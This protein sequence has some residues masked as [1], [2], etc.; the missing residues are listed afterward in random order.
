MK[1]VGVTKCPS[2]VAH[3][4]MA[5]EMLQETGEEM[6]HE[7]RIETQGSVGTE[8]E[9]T[10][11][12]IEA[13]DYVVIAADIAIDGMERFNGKKV[14]E[15]PIQPVLQDCEAV[16]N[17]LPENA[18]LQGGE[19]GAESTS[20]SG[21]A[22]PMKALMDGASHMI[23]FVVTG[24][25][26]M[27]LATA[28]GGVD[29]S[30]NVATDNAFWYTTYQVGSLAFSL[31]YPILA[32]YIANAIAGR[33][34][35]APAMISAYVA[36]TP[37]VLGTESSMGFL[38][39]VLSGFLA[40]YLVKWMN[41]WNVGKY[42]KPL[43]PIFIIPLVGTALISALYICV[44]GYPISWIMDW[45]SWALETLAGN[46]ATSWALSI[47][48]GIMISSDMGGPINKVAF[49]TGTASI[50]TGA[51]DVM[52]LVAVAIPIPALVC[53]LATLL[54]P[55][56]YT[57]EEK[58]SGISALVMGFTGLTEGA[59]P[60]A[61]S[62]PLHVIPSCMVGTCAGTIVAGWMG[63]ECSIPW[64]GPIVALLGATNNILGY[65]V[66]CI[67]GMVV[68]GIMLAAWK[69]HSDSKKA[70]EAETAEA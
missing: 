31:M 17:G 20:S 36:V 37:E 45:L 67:I 32:G 26:F 38:G 47:V 61:T 14:L 39:C 58:G 56:G 21:G 44:L 4:Y 66:C 12:E 30:G 55:K 34:A 64:G 43:M 27:A 10:A 18:K 50:T 63:I 22:D 69:R 60:F 52:G 7:V 42:V 15:T 5:A 16:I 35:L 62:D 59:I 19:A 13:A 49:L 65:F 33:A 48:I 1:I 28:F 68:G 70:A 40:G 3:T 41:S 54:Y 29:A 24:G 51:L 57:D 46:P 53:G 2:G 6:G 11:E 9:L 8:D 23:P 25:L